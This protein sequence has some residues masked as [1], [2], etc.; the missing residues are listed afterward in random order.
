MD[1]P[2]INGTWQSPARAGLAGLCLLTMI[3]LPACTADQATGK[4]TAAP[5]VEKATPDASTPAVPET[6]TNAPPAH[7]ATLGPGESR[8]TP[9]P[10]PAPEPFPLQLDPGILIGLG[11]EQTE[12]MM[13]KPADVRDEPPATVWAYKSGDCTLEV[14]FYPEVETRQ[15][16]ALAYVVSGKDQSDAAKQ[17]CFARIRTA[18]RD[19]QS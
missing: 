2:P 1:A 6:P 9:L 13:G 12:L 8:A 4:S 18:R 14:F 15:P 10:R 16:R 3:V 5:A 19:R 17:A 7:T 11:P